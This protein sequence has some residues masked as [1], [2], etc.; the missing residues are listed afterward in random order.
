MDFEDDLILVLLKKE[1]KEKIQQEA[2]KEQ[3]SLSTF[4][5]NQILEGMKNN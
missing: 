4:C 5:L 1:M 3:L 2:E